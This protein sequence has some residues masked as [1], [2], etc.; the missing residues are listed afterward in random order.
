MAGERTR[1]GSGQT[2]ELDR[3]TNGR[4]PASKPGPLESGQTSALAT[5]PSRIDSRVDDE[6]FLLC[7]A[8]CYLGLPPSLWRTITNYFLEAVS[9]EY[10]EQYGEAKGSQEFQD[11]KIAFQ[12][13]S[14]FN[15]FKALITFLAGEGVVGKLAL[16]S[17]AAQLVRT[18]IVELL[19][20]A[21]V[22]SGAIAGASQI[23]R[24]FAIFLEL[25]WIAG[26]GGY[27]GSM[28]YANAILTFSK[29]VTDA[30]IAFLDVAS[31]LGQA[32]NSLMVTIFVRPLVVSKAML[33]PSNWDT[34][35]MGRGAL[36]LSLL[37]NALWPKL[38]A[39]N[40]DD[41]LANV[42]KPMSSFNFPPS[43]IDEI[44]K[45]MTNAFNARGGFQVTFTSVLI[46][47]LTPL[48]FVQLL[49]DWR[50]LRFKKD[51]EQL[52]DEAL[53]TMPKE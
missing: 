43:A 39:D 44:A 30:A 50:L 24:K 8:L 38:K 40:A 10:R 52:A 17:V 6:G 2:V 35:P 31:A 25:A 7:L 13:W 16:K 32:T 47:D 37:G 28:A 9:A 45:E 41:F 49:R 42:M 21:G 1:D 18:K 4:M 11:F 26:C 46:L 22:K 48:T 53:G 34:T 51:P 33:D 19:A 27:C 29:V 5:A 36:V 12:S 15:K 14:T 20:R 3:G 23:V